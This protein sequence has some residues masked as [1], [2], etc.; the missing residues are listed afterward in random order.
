[1]C[2]YNII[3]LMYTEAVMSNT[4]SLDVR[5]E[6]SPPLVRSVLYR[7]VDIKWPV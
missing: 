7:N 4:V 6:L 1:M 3:S 2:E 5:T